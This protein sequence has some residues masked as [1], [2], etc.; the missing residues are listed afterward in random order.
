MLQT[1]SLLNIFS[2]GKK[3]KIKY[4]VT[5]G[6]LLLAIVIANAENSILMIPKYSANLSLYYSSLSSCISSPDWY[7][8]CLP[9][10]F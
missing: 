7:Y 1:R 9:Q 10:I 5:L 4:I 2:G 6:L 3:M 8:I